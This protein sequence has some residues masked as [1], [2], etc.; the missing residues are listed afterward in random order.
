M[1]KSTTDK[2]Q[3][4]AQIIKLLESNHQQAVNAALQA[5][6][7][8]TDDENIAENKYDTL[9]LEASYL[10]QGQAQ[11]VAQ[12][13]SDLEIYTN[14]T[15]LAFSTETPISLGALITLIDENKQEKILFLGPTAGGLT[16]KTG[17][18][19]I[20]LITPSSPLAKNLIGKK[21]GDEV[22]MNIGHQHHA[23][24]VSAVA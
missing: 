11:R 20:S 13:V 24:E 5:Y 10:A 18:R 12:L 7:T 4:I 1:N 23:Y 14:F 15:P 6:N 2:A 8:A 17:D 19:D 9:G 3:I 21:T 16:F 22:K